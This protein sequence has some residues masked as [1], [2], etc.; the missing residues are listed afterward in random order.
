M[1]YPYYSR[2]GTADLILAHKY[3]SRLYLYTH[4]K[5]LTLQDPRPRVFSEPF[6]VPEV[7]LA[8]AFFLCAEKA[9]C[10]NNVSDPGS[11]LGSP[12]F[13]SFCTPWTPPRH[14]RG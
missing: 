10:S 14:E 1:L 9:S 13:H 7:A 4:F 5:V 3:I 8:E 12:R 2:L 11:S 6:H